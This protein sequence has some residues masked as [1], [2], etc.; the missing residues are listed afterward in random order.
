MAFMDIKNPRPR[1][2]YLEIR[3]E[4]HERFK[5][6]STYPSKSPRASPLPLA[7]DYNGGRTGQCFTHGQKHMADK[8]FRDLYKIGKEESAT[9][10]GQ[11]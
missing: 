3:D 5:Y 11:G 8:D 7:R 10:K 2:S 9:A 1:K 4:V 6:V